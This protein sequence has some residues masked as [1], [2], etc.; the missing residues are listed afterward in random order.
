MSINYSAKK[1]LMDN[2]LPAVEI[3]QTSNGITLISERIAGASNNSI[4]NKGRVF[5]VDHGFRS[6]VCTQTETPVYNLPPPPPPPQL[7]PKEKEGEPGERTSQQ[8]FE[9]VTAATTGLD[10]PQKKQGEAKEFFGALSAATTGMEVD[11]NKEK[12]APSTAAD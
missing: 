5:N 2:I 4:R 3:S 6:N 7:K 1:L 9:S 12:K 10:V 11:E 8:F